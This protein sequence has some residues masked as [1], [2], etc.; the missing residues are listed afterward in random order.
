MTLLNTRTNLA[1]RISLDDYSTVELQEIYIFY[2][3][4]TDYVVLYDEL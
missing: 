4:H 3:N 1:K 2:S